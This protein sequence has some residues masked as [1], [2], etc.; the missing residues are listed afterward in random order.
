MKEKHDPVAVARPKLKAKPAAKPKQTNKTRRRKPSATSRA[1]TRSKDDPWQ[2][3][4][5]AALAKRGVVLDACRAAH[6]GRATAYEHKA[7]DPEFAK[8]WAAALEEAADAM[9]HEAWRRAVEGLVRKKFTRTGEPITDPA[10]G[11]QYFEREYSDSLLQFL[12]KASRPGKFRET[13]KV[14]HSG[15]IG[16]LTP[17]QIEEKRKERW[18][19]VRPALMRAL[20]ETSVDVPEVLGIASDEANEASGDA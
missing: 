11:N 9:E 15:E 17:E 4:F 6:V 12:L 20:V 13:A 16:V 14:E 5:I 10:T 8:A 3:R 18:K 19:D 1:A 2:P 7:A